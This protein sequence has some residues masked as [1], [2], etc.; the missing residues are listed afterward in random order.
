M[1]RF[2]VLAII[3]IFLNCVSYVT[4]SEIKWLEPIY[5]INPNQVISIDTTTNA[6]GTIYKVKYKLKKE[7]KE[8][9]IERFQ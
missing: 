4:I 3:L 7:K 5:N 9:T 8:D 1:K 6:Y 2:L